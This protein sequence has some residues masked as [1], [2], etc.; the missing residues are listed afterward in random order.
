MTVF[1]EREENFVKSVANI[2][3]YNIYTPKKTRVAKTQLRDKRC[4]RLLSV[5]KAG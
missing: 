4:P 3:M 1:S 2:Y 5:G